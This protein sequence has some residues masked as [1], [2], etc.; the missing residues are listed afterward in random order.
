MVASMYGAAG[1]A[2]VEG[3][4]LPQAITAIAT[5]AML[6]SLGILIGALLKTESM[7]DAWVARTKVSRS[8][9]CGLGSLALYRFQQVTCRKSSAS[10]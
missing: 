7:P 8:P 3:L 1:A 2:G 10:F 5:K 4:E 6:H 9:S